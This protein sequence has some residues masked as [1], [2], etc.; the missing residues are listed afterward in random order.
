MEI[1]KLCKEIGIETAKDLIRFKAENQ[2]IGDDL[3]TALKSYRKGLGEDF[4]IKQWRI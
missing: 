3:L 4:R 2:G 1:L